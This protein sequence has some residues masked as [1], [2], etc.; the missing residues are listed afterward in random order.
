[1]TTTEKELGATIDQALEARKKLAF[2]NQT[3]ASAMSKVREAGSKIPGLN[4]VM[5]KID[6]ARKRDVYVLAGVISACI[7][8]LLWWGLG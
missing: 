1:M 3:L 5:N 8:F 4:E 7:C 2:Q 6:K